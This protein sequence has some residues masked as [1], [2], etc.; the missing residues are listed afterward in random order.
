MEEATQTT[1]ATQETVVDVPWQRDAAGEETRTAE[2][3]GDGFPE[4]G[5]GESLDS[6][7]FA[8]T[9]ERA[10]LLNEI[11]RTRTFVFFA[12]TLVLCA[13][14]V[15]FLIGGD[16]TARWVHIGG[17]GLIALVAIWIL[18]VTR[19]ADSYQPW[20]NTA[21][22]MSCVIGVGGPFYYWGPYSAVLLVVPFGTHIFA[23]GES[24]LAALMIHVAVITVHVTIA[25]LILFDVVA[26]RGV[27]HVPD[28]S[29]AAQLVI[30][31]LIQ[32]IFVAT[33]AVARGLRRSAVRSHKQLDQAAR[34]VARRD[35]LL[36]EAKQSL[37][38]ALQIGGPGPYTGSTVGSFVLG[39]LLGRGAMGEVYEARR[40]GTDEL[41]A[42]KM[43]HP[44]VLS[45]PHHF[46]R[47]VRESEIAAS[48]RVDNVVRVL[49]VSQGSE[50]VPYIAMER[51]YGE[52]LASYMRGRTR[53]HS[54]EV[55][56]MI[57]QVGAGLAAAHESGIVHRD[58]KPQNIFRARDGERVTWKI[59]D[60]GVSKLVDTDESLTAG[61]VIGTP[62]YMA[63]EQARMKEIDRRADLYALGV[64]TYRALTGMPAFT[65]PDIPE[66]LHAVC[67]DMP[68]PPST[69]AHLSPAVD[70]VIA[71]AIAKRPED[72]FAS[73]ADLAKH[74]RRALDGKV[75]PEVEARARRLLARTGWRSRAASHHR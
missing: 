46:Q 61:H 53:L 72:R 44:H 14:L 36:A 73:G 71:V 24:F 68:A 57:E 56:D 18:W 60:F 5:S 39:N 28:I 33:F 12:L 30:L 23:M 49:E 35:A 59:L 3:D 48:L 38:R 27:M 20:F 13:N 26:D 54:D 51:L 32:F 41:C 55:L 52:D 16:P 64:I 74:L 50:T 66:I 21:F 70:A 4:A 8:T 15:T 58:L 75:A 7:A 31:G 2:A 63:P 47:F 67:Y 45:S 42:I 11:E 43:L 34:A 40:Q 1:E 25:S 17:T 19:A 22:G 37:N 65:G 29:L 69:I 6:A 62:S 10:L 9:P